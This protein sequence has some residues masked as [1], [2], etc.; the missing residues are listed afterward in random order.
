[1]FWFFLVEWH[2]LVSQPVVKPTPPASEGEVLTI[3]LPGKSPPRFVMWHAA[4]S[5][6]TTRSIVD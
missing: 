6:A 1:M 4:T 2:G 5:S 3:G